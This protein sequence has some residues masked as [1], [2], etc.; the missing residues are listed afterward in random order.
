MIKKIIL[1][2]ITVAFIGCG[3][4]TKEQN[5]KAVQTTTSPK[6]EVVANE[7]AK[8]IKVAIKE[9]N[10]SEE[11]TFYKG[12][13]NDLVHTY[14]PNSQPANKDA[15]VRVRPRTVIDANM[16]IRS[17]YEKLQIS[18][19]V[20][21]L[22]KDFIVKCSACHDDYANGVIGPSLLGKSSDE[23]FDKIIAFKN[24][25]KSN[26]LMDGLIDHM[27]EK[28]IRKIADEISDFNKKIEEMRRNR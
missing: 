9:G 8:E 16:H 5:K 18:L 25:T 12:M 3:D 19:L 4:D 26:V 17:P 10:G 7:N 15:S 2:G 1:S 22:S 21:K 20:K 27:D 6:I 24:G 11:S 13:T 28:N 14:D 23:I